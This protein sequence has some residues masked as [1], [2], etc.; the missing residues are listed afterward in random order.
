[1]QPD[2]R[3]VRTANK[4]ACDL[5]EKELTQIEGYRGGQVFDCVHAFTVFDSDKYR[6]D[7]DKKSWARFIEFLTETFN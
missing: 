3:Q 1:M 4:K 2:P 6:E 5:F 7:A